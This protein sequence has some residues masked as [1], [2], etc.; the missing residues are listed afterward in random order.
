MVMVG[1][2]VTAWPERRIL[3][4]EQQDGGPDTLRLEHKRSECP[5]RKGGWWRA[6]EQSMAGWK[7]GFRKE[8]QGPKGKATG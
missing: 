8:S 2:E 3:E 1:Q 6:P 7:Q 4:Q 5:A